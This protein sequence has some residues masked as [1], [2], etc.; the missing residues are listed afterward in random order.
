MPLEIPAYGSQFI[1]FRKPISADQAGQAVCNYPVLSP[2]MEIKGSW[3]VKFDPQWGAPES[4]EFSE[5]ADWTSRPEDGIRYYSGSATYQLN[6]DYQPKADNPSPRI[7]LDLGDLNNVAEVRLNGNTLGVL[8]TR[9]YRVEISG[10]VKKGANS[11][12]VD[13]INLWPNRLIGDG[14]LPPE[15][16]FTQTNIGGYYTGN[17]KLFPSGLLGPVRVMIENQ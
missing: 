15:K 12:A 14:K 11:L 1:V 8:W 16:R 13:I 10:A 6:F 2:L 9:P 5:L 3:T 7:H 17:H 4:V